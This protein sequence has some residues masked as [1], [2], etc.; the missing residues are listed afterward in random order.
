L[1]LGKN[2]DTKFHPEDHYCKAQIKSVMNY[3]ALIKDKYCI[4]DILILSI[5]DKAKIKIGVPAVSR[6][7]HSRK[8]FEIHNEP[9]TPDHDFPI[10]EKLLITPS[11]NQLILI[12][13]LINIGYLELDLKTETLKD[14]YERT[15]YCKPANS[16]LHIVNRPFYFVSTSAF[17]HAKDIY[18]I[19]QAKANKPSV[20]ALTSD[21]GPDF[22]PNSYLVFIALG[23]LW[24][25]ID[26]D[27]LFISSYAPYNSRYNSIE[28]AWGTM[29]QALAQIVLCPQAKEYIQREGGRVE[30]FRIAM[31]ELDSIWGKTYY[32][33]KL[34]QTR[35]IDPLDAE[36]QDNPF[37]DYES[38]KD[39]L[40]KGEKSTFYTK[41]KP[42]IKFLFRHCYRRSYYLHF[43]KCYKLD[44]SHCFNKIRHRESFDVLDEIDDKFGTLPKPILMD[45]VYDGEHYASFLDYKNSE[46]LRKNIKEKLEKEEKKGDKCYFCNW[47]F[48]SSNDKKKHKIFCVG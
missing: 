17:S 21:N 10:S 23:R 26:L 32:A 9:T 4:D 35:S 5:D 22:S 16:Q 19:I 13:Y 2:T 14:K 24:K 28:I 37:S 15:F 33:E 27:Q 45:Q 48:G 30:M 20:L 6:Y 31:A 8:Y 40:N 1:C 25:L 39:V 43:K 12:F 38:V 11:G 42:E 3:L 46:T 47:Y 18:Q 41:Y 36:Y 29:S 7:V 34:V 44:C